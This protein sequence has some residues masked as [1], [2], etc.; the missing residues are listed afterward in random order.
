MLPPVLAMLD[1]PGR[2]SRI[3]ALLVA[4]L[5]VATI[6]LIGQR[7]PAVLTVLGLVRL[8]RFAAAPP[9]GR[10]HG[11]SPGGGPAH[12]DAPVITPRPLPSWSCISP[13]RVE[14]FGQSAY[15][16]LYIRATVMSLAH[17]IIGLGFDGFRHGCYDALYQRGLPW[18]G[19]SD[20]QAAGPAG[21]SI[22]PA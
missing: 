19:I 11:G 20:A 16:L 18:L 5:G 17:P 14:H 22:H 15:G 12:R 3:T 6:L 7:M 13:T 21:C 2:W 4:L 10:D 8:W 9:P 1:R